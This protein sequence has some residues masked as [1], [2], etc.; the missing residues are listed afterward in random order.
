MLESPQSA[1]LLVS[2]LVELLQELPGVHARVGQVEFA[3]SASGD[4][5]DPPRRATI[6]LEVADRSL[7]V[8]I[9]ARRAVYPRD[10]RQAIW[11]MRDAAHAGDVGGDGAGSV[12][13]LLAAES[14]SPGAK[15]LL[16][17]EGV[18]YYD[19]GGSLY[20]PAA[21]VLLYIDKPPP[22]S[23]VRSMRSL[24]TGRRAQVLHALLVHRQ[25]WFGVNE[26]AQ[27]A[28]VSP[29][30]VSQVLR[31]LERLDWL[32]TKGQGPSKERHLREPAAL[33]DAWVTQLAT[34]RAPDLQRYYV[35]ATK[36]EA[37]AARIDESLQALEVPYAVSHEAAAQRLAPFL[38]SVSQVRLRL[39]P[40]A[41]ADAALAQLGARPV[42]EGANLA[43]ID[44]KSAGEL[45]FRERHEGLWLAS[46]V[47]IYLDLMRGE[48][49]AKE[50]AAHFRKEG[51]GF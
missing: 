10:V 21:G 27:L 12:V 11:Q 17:R 22:R 26:L 32:T 7:T 18:G 16:R 6:A 45:L 1:S 51:M 50:L 19:S 37:L 28:Q 44:T 13:S 48:G 40:G 2:H 43:L 35:P 36:P 3:A 20:L 30:T 24:F 23:Q 49:R 39:L 42:T 46:P 8:R 4:W 14:I 31:E 34:E 38:S 41:A 33:L 47:Q 9:E 15:D 5:L 29:A 25:A